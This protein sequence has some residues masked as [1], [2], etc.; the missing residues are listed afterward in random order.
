MGICSSGSTGMPKVIVIN[1]P[2]VYHDVFSTPMIAMWGP[3]PTPQTILVVAPMYH[4]T[5]FHHAEQHARRRPPVI[6]Q[7]FDAAL[8][9][10]VIERHRVSTFTATPTMLKRISD[11]PDIDERDC[12]ASNGS[13]RARRRCPRASS[14]GGSN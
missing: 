14:S 5:G 9:V 10:D 12:R 6:M 4:S 11:L 13:C 2:A 7:K 8:I 1:R 3:V